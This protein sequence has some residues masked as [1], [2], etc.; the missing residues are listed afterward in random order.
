MIQK[1]ILLQDLQKQLHNAEDDQTKVI[2]N[3]II[4]DVL[5]G[6]FNVRVW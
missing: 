6:K 2:L 5:S 3:G 4:A 1:D